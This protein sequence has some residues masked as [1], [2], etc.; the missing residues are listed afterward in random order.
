MDIVERSGS[1]RKDTLRRSRVR[2]GGLPSPE[3]SDILID[4]ER[5]VRGTYI[6]GFPEPEGA[7]QG[8][9]E[10]LRVLRGKSRCAESSVA[11]KVLPARKSPLVR[12]R[13]PARA[14]IRL[15]YCIIVN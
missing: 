12:A 11:R 15:L 9:P 2:E 13:L 6:G 1:V 10:A 7:I 8:A 4:R 14:K 3:E 5:E